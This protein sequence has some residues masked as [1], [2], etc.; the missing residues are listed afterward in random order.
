MKTSSTSDPSLDGI[1]VTVLTDEESQFGAEIVK[2]LDCSF[3]IVCHFAY[4][5]S[6]W[7]ADGC[8]QTPTLKR[9]G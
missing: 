2:R 7:T 4:N 8:C 1:C 3:T 9:N 6:S 5:D